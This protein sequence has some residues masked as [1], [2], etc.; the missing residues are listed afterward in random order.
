M[1]VYESIASVSAELAHSGISKDRNNLQQGY[2]FRGIDDCLNA[3][4]PLLA[5]HHLVLLP[6]VLERDKAER[7][8]K[9]GGALFYVTVKVKYV[10]VNTEDFSKHD[11]ITYGEAMDTADKATNKAMSAAYKYAVIQA[12]C[13]PTEGDNDADATTY[14]VKASP[15]RTVMQSKQTAQAKIAELRQEGNKPGVQAAGPS[16]EAAPP[17]ASNSTPGPNPAVSDEDWRLFVEYCDEDD[18]RGEVKDEAKKIFAC[19]D[20]RKLPIAKRLDF[21]LKVQDMAEKRGVMFATW[22]EVQ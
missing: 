2:K 14:D 1:K 19:T 17:Q 18:D 13:I 4:A 15:V 5:K 10:F 20:L 3:L 21:M 12:F 22:V 9:Q 11:V 16:Q 7:E 6:E 8:T